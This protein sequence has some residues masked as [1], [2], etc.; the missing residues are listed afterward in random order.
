MIF[1]T[2]QEE[3]QIIHSIPLPAM[4]DYSDDVV[5]KTGESIHIT[6]IN[7]KKIYGRLQN[8]APE[9]GIFAIQQIENSDLDTIE[10]KNIKMISFPLNR[11][12]HKSKEKPHTASQGFMMPAKLQKF[13]VE[14]NDG[15][16]LEGET[17]GLR[18]DMNG[19]FL[20]PSHDTDFYHIIYLN[21]S[22]VKRYNIGPKLGEVLVEDSVVTEEGV[23][24]GL[25]VQ[26]DERQKPIGE[27]LRSRAVVTAMDLESALDRQKSFPNM[28]LG[29]ILTSENLITD[30][31]LN[32]ALE[33]QKKNKKKPLGE[34]LV[35]KGLVT[36]DEIQISL[37]KK[38]GIPF[39]DVNL[40]DI[41]EE[42]LRLVDESVAEQ[43]NVLPLYHFDGKLAVA[44]ENP[45]DSQVLDAVRFQSNCIVEPV[46]GNSE[47]I[48]KVI[49]ES[50]SR[51]NIIDMDDDFL[52]EDEFEEELDESA[53]SDNVVVKLVNKIILDAYNKGASD[54]HIEPYPGQKMTQV[55][56]RRDGVLSNHVKIPASLRTAV[57]AR[58]KIMAG[59]N[60]SERRRPQDGKINFRKFSRHKFELR[61]ATLPTSEQLEDVVIR[62]LASGEPL[63]ISEMG[64]DESTY[65][66]LDR[67]I[68]TPYGLFLTCGPTGSGKTTTLHSILKEL[69]TAERKIWT[70]EDPIEITQP[71]LRQLQV[72]P[73]IDVTFASAMRA[74]LRAD[75]D[76]IM[77]GEM[78]DEETIKIA[79]EA[80][81]TGHMVFST[82][83][84]NSAPESINRLLEMGMDPF[85][86]GD[87][88]VGVLAQ[89]L[90]RRLCKHCKE[91]YT[92]TEE[93]VD[94]L[95]A[96]YCQDMISVGMS[97]DEITSMK[98]LTLTRWREI[99]DSD[100]SGLELYRAKGC[101]ECG[102]TGYAG[103]LGIYELL[104]NS[105]ALNHLII[106]KGSVTE[107]KRQAIKEGMLT[108]K[109]DGINKVIQGI[110]DISQIR[111]VCSS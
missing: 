53:A 65:K 82:L 44:L 37:A 69:N 25:A 76:V 68:H 111:R 7:Q 110:T 10:N 58:I 96:E 45:M 56:I 108:L 85:N 106:T 38:M 62:I 6:D 81:L 8:Y 100:Q 32:L 1:N 95:L 22:M 27:Y 71:G 26:A 12:Y 60:I 24:E 80:S 55:R 52:D 29:V 35:D 74:F 30:E 93:E 13:T 104:V 43:Y 61:V 88:L 72:A 21:R 73:K 92:A 107:I 23:Q 17:R 64:F 90:T 75:P 19:I 31:Q 63:S 18:V 34:I 99:Q 41:D 48:A 105:E 87:A 47:E 14:F 70:V 102:D 77:V 57:V 91:Q 46:M 86:F 3:K 42:A 16:V 98:Q 89:R 2:K 28:R 84:T 103:R 54:I 79:I 15:D 101:R 83:H 4:S 109:Q 94:E 11:K 97:D 67:L 20:F 78:R 59:M 40:F 49:S 5:V 51:L 50:Y 66:N 33:E 36:R 39:V 9:T